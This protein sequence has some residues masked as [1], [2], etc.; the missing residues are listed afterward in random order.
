M[1]AFETAASLPA[2]TRILA[3]LGAE[4]ARVMEPPFPVSPYM[5]PFDGTLMN[6]QPIALDLK[7]PDGP[8]LAKRLAAAADVVCNNFRP[9]VMRR[10][11]LDHETLRASNPRLIVL[12]LSGYG[13]PGPWQD[14]P[15]YGPSVE[16][17]GGMNGSMGDESQLPQRVGGGVFADT[18]GGR[19]AALA[20]CAALLHRDRTG[21]GQYIDAAMY[22]AIV[23]GIG[24]LVAEASATDAPP[25]RYGNRHERFAPQGV[26]PALGNDQWIAISVTSDEQWCALRQTIADARLDDP[27]Y[28]D[29]TGRRAAHDAIDAVIATWTSTR[30]KQ[31]AAEALQAAGVPAGPVQWPGD[32]PFD[33][34]HRARGF[35]QT[36]RHEIPPLLGYRTHP[37]MTMA[38][39]AIGYPRAPLSDHQPEGSRTEAVLRRWLDATDEELAAWRASGVTPPERPIIADGTPPPAWF[40]E[41]TAPR[42]EHFAERLGLEP[43]SDVGEAR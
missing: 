30:D 9:P 21:D 28:E 7:H 33:P 11:G 23:T 29:E 19:Y 26:Y 38:A 34:Q 27:A 40:G 4:V 41:R 20:I 10:F 43:A 1:L 35:L 25:K 39:R 3:D 22:E 6:K 14:Y 8:A 2:G 36:V 15:A 12:Q 5:R 24:D 18:V 37:Y 16:A 17:A 32:V 42:D 31:E 13:T